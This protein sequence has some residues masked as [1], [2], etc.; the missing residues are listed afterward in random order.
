MRGEPLLEAVATCALLAWWLWPTVAAPAAWLRV[1]RERLGDFDSHLVPYLAMRPAPGGWLWDPLVG[2]GRPVAADPLAN[3]FDP[4]ATIGLALVDPR[5][6]LGP[7]LFASLVLA[8]A[9]AWALARD[10][11]CGRLSAT[12]VGLGFATSGFTLAHLYAGHLEFILALPAL[13]LAW[14]GARRLCGGRKGG[15][16]WTGLAFALPVLAGGPYF[17]ELASLIVFVVICRHGLAVLWRRIWQTL[18]LLAGRVALAAMLA[19]GLSAIHLLPI[20]LSQSVIVRPPLDPFGGTQPLL[21]A[22]RNWLGAPESYKVRQH[23]A[24]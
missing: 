4:I 2:F 20:L 3:V 12:V 7:V 5:V 21:G 9:A 18:F 24:A 14:L 11:D 17:A 16:L 8:A 22:M 10:A 23:P 1:T 6:G 15:I 19:I 13:P